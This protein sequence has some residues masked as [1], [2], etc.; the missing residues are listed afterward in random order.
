M[1]E[2][3]YQAHLTE[4]GWETVLDQ[5]SQEYHAS[6]RRIADVMVGWAKHIH[7]YEAKG[8]GRVVTADL[9]AQWRDLIGEMTGERRFAVLTAMVRAGV[10]VPEYRVEEE[11]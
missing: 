5:A 6:V 2:T 11:G 8:Y 9:S 10:E 7:E 4:K 3:E 1:T